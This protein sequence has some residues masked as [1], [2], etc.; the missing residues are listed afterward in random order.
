VKKLRVRHVVNG[1]TKSDTYL[2]PDGTDVSATVS[3]VQGADV[4]NVNFTDETGPS[5]GYDE[6][7]R[8]VEWALYTLNTRAVLTRKGKT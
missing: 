6:R 2:V 3:A 8:E 5:F 4:V 1:S 7:G